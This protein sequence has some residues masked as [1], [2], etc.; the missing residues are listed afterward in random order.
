MK[1][2]SFSKIVGVRYQYVALPLNPIKSSSDPQAT[3]MGATAFF[4][5]GAVMYNPLSSPQGN[6]ALDK[7]WIS[8]DPCHGHSSPDMQYHYHAVSIFCYVRMYP[9]KCFVL[10]YLY[11]IYNYLGF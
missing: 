11:I 2:S 5:S 6:L 8:L 10:L 1:I 4:N 3:P 9:L 7:E